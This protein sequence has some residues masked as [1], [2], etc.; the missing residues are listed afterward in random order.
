MN[1]SWSHEL[2]SLSICLVGPKTAATAVV[3]Q[4][5]RWWVNRRNVFF[6]GLGTAGDKSEQVLLTYS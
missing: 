2:K 1:F 5:G 6:H 3:D 4:L